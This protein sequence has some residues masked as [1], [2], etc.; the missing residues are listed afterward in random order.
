MPEVQSYGIRIRYDD[1]GQGEP[2]LLFMPRWC[3]SRKVFDELAPCC[4]QWRR[5]LLL[6]WRW[7]G[8][9]HAPDQDFGYAELL[10][11]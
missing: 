1:H 4:A 2:A 7:H 9:S 5:T 8:K 10:T 3:G 6:D 11:E